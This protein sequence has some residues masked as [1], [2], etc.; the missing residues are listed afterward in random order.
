MKVEIHIQR[1]R[2]LTSFVTSLAAEHSLCMT[3]WCGILCV[4]TST[5]SRTMSLSNRAW[6]L[7]YSLGTWVHSALETFATIACMYHTIPYC[8]V[9]WIVFAR[10]W[11]VLM[12]LFNLTVVFICLCLHV[13]MVWFTGWLLSVCLCQ[14]NRHLK[15][16]TDVQQC[17]CN[18][19]L[20]FSHN[21][22]SWCTL[23]WDNS[24]VYNDV[25]FYII[26]R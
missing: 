6:K 5:Y 10:A 26:G 25:Q 18:Y 15:N 17:C 24:G 8:R 4:T 13:L 22:L 1:I 11:W 14:G 7:G 2:I 3:R 23:P 21:C 9:S 19:V 20:W 16:W 12:P